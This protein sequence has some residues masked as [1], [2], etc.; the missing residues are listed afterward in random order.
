MGFFKNLFGSSDEGKPKTFSEQFTQLAEPIIVKRYRD[1]FQG[2]IDKVS[3]QKILDVY[4]QVISA[5]TEEAKSRGERIPANNLNA[6]VPKFLLLYATMGEEHYYS[7]LK[8][9]IDRYHNYG[10]RA[11]YLEKE[12]S[13]F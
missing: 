4:K 5:F 12:I 1:F 13:L 3:D 11:E 7:H 2:T 6:I 9:E 8:Y 10:L